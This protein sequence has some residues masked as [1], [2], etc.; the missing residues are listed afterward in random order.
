MK[1]LLLSLTLLLAA[2]TA[3]RAEIAPY[4]SEIS[5]GDD[6]RTVKDLYG[7]GAARSEHDY[8][9]YLAYDSDFFEQPCTLEFAFVDDRLY[10]VSITAKRLYLS[11]PEAEK[12]FFAINDKLKAT[13]KPAEYILAKGDLP[14][15]NDTDFSA[16]GYWAGV[17]TSAFMEINTFVTEKPLSLY[18]I[19]RTHPNGEQSDKLYSMLA[20]AYTMLNGRLYDHALWPYY[21]FTAFILA[22]GLGILVYI[23][24]QYI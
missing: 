3:A 23:V 1:H 10:Q 22:A 7:P 13:F 17:E 8:Y 12:L 18:F 5:W 24:R 4:F 20:N 14:K 19:H 9:R 6:S 2:A 11:G 15:G 21:L 16:R